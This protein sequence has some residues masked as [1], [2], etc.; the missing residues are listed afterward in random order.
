MST[1]SIDVFMLS[2]YSDDAV[3]ASGVVNQ[4]VI[5]V[6]IVYMITTLGTA[7]LCAQYLGAK[8][9]KNVAQV[10]GLSLLINFVVGILVSIGLYYF[11]PQLLTLMGLKENLMT[12]GIPYMW[13]IGGS[14]FLLALAM[15]LG[16]ILRSFKK[17]YYPMYVAALINLINIVGNYLLIFGHGGFPVLGISGAGISTALC[18]LVAVVLMFI[19]LFTKVMPFPKKS[20]FKPF[21]WDKIKN[22]LVVG[23]PGAGENVSYSLSQVLITYFA[24]LLGTASLTARTY[25]MN[26]VMFSYMFA[27]AMGHGVAIVI[28]HLIGEDRSNAAFSIEKYAIRWAIGVSL[29]ISVGTALLGTQI[30]SWLSDNPDVI[31]LG[32]MV[33]YI[34][35]I[36]EIGRAVN[37]A[38]V[39]SLIAAG[40]VMYPFW[41]GIIVMWLVAT[42]GAYVLGI[43]LGWGLN[44]IWVAMAL[45]ELIRAAIFERR[46]RSRRWENKSFTR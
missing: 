20:Y 42:L 11:A 22:L 17:A 13:L 14:S 26:I 15:T 40:D 10:V 2:R 16:A 32:A 27:M 33:L 30:F 9:K 6:S 25:A 23:L 44:G 3:A 4:L 35:V 29:L 1:G 45:D 19:I 37:I 18:R 46:W 39:N 34:D 41:T 38:S 24:V 31:R 5:L 12:Y 8:Q 43:K 21:P 7:V 28:G 36:L